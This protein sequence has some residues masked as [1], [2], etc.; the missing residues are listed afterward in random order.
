MNTMLLIINLLLYSDM[1]GHRADNDSGD[2]GFFEF[3]YCL[4][5]IG[6]L[7]LGTLFYLSSTEKKDKAW[8]V[9]CLL[10]IIVCVVLCVSYINSCV[11]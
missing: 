2:F 9:A 4:I 5:G 8:G 11:G 10:G 6:I 1:S 3:L 7:G